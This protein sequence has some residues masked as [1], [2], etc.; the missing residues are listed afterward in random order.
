MTDLSVD[1]DV[2]I[3]EVPR[4]GRPS[5]K[6]PSLEVGES[7]FIEAQSPKEIRTARARLASG[8]KGARV[9]GQTFVT[10]KVENGVRLWRTA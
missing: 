9:S 6:W 1:K 4:P 10:R 7:L 3:P 2:P 8:Y 5:I